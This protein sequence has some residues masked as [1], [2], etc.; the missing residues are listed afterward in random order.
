MISRLR[1]AGL[2]EGCTLL[3]LVGVAVPL[4]HL[5]G[6]PLAVMIMGPIHGV[7]FLVYAMVLVETAT[8]EGWPR[9][10]WWR[11]VLACLFPFG[12]FVND[13]WLRRR[14]ISAEAAPRA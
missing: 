5:A 10:D 6:L 1:L 4:K 9:R 12:T 3:T 14:A 13:A 11:A 2:V 7:A 8:S